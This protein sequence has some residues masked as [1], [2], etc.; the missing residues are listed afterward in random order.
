MREKL[1]PEF[2]RLYISYPIIQFFEQVH[3]G[4]QLVNN[5]IEQ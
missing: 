1:F 5:N 4:V 2:G 3:A